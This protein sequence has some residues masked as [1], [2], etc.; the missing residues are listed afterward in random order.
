MKKVTELVAELAAPAVAEQGCTLWDVEY[1]REAGQWYLRLYLDKD[2]GVD[3]LDCE[4]SAA[5]SATCWTRR[6]P[7]RAAIPLRCPPPGPSAP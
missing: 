2:G 4:A 1:V 5:R 6:T 7:S 3:I